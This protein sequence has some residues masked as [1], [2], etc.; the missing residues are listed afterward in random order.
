[1]THMRPYTIQGGGTTPTSAMLRNLRDSNNH[2]S[3]DNQYSNHPYLI[4]LAKAKKE[5]SE[6]DILDTFRKVEINIPLLEAIRQLPKYAKLLKGLCTNR[7][8]LNLQ[9]KVRVGENVSTVLQRKLPQ[10]C[11]DPGMFT[12]PCTIGQKR[13]ERG[14]LDLG[15]SIN[16]MLLSIFKALNLEPLK[17]IRVV[18][19]LADRSNVYPGGV[20]EDVLVKVNEFFFPAN[21][22]IV[23]MNDDNSANSTVLLLDRPFM[24]MARTNIDVHE[25]TFSVEFDGETITFNIFDVMKL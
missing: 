24:S 22:H 5:E 15:I 16:I 25:G 8:K 1:M 7:N 9:D 19:Q 2:S 11:K 18:I 17:E 3:K 4:Q 21:F 14:M 12:I 13:I 20:V 10:K 23:D 6:K